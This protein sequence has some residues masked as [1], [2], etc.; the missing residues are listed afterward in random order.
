ME[1][2]KAIGPTSTP[3]AQ[4]GTYPPRQGNDIQILIFQEN[5]FI[6]LF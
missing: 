6:F 4:N 3:W 1:V 5:V 2:S